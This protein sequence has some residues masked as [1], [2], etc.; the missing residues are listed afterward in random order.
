MNYLFDIAVALVGTVIG[1]IIVAVGAY[2]ILNDYIKQNPEAY[3][4]LTCPD[5]VISY[6]YLRRNLSDLYSQNLRIAKIERTI[7]DALAINRKTDLKALEPALGIRF[8][9]IQTKPE[10]PIPNP[11][12]QELTTDC[13]I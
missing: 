6:L 10:E 2:S 9:S 3:R 4:V 7:A 12:K 8:L 5:A 13:N 11:P 1:V